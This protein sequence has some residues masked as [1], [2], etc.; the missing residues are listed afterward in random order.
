MRIFINGEEMKSKKQIKI[1]VN[2]LTGVSKTPIVI[3]FSLVVFLTV[4][5][6]TLRFLNF[7]TRLQVI[8]KE[9]V[10]IQQILKENK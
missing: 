2:K 7:N 8:Q 10:T 3:I 6:V 4:L 9:L 1:T 5:G